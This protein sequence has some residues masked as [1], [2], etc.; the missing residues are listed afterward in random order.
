M[1]YNGNDT[2]VLSSERSFGHSGFLV[3]YDRWTVRELELDESKLR[4]YWEKF[5][6][7]PTLGLER[8]ETDC[9]E[10]VTRFTT[11]GSV[12]LEFVEDGAPCGL[13]ILDD[14]K[15]PNCELHAYFFDRKLS[16]KTDVSRYVVKMIFATFA[17]H[18]LFSV[19]P[20]IYF[21]TIRLAKRV[22][23]REE[24]RLREATMIR[25]KWADK[26]ILAI[27]REEVL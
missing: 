2:A 11:R 5:L 12:F 21:S 4:W 8:T 27:L 24:G 14:V 1:D 25:G 7:F 13:W 6:E 22:G 17:L 18:R 23:L 19:I 10:F 20:T 16:E 9:T 15:G 26:T 3:S